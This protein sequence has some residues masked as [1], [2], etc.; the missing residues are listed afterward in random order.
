[1]IMKALVIRYGGYGDLIQCSSVFA[2]LHDQG[3]EVTLITDTKESQVVMHDPNLSSIITM[4]KSEEWIMENM[5]KYDKVICLDG[6]VEGHLLARPHSNPCFWPPDSREKVF[7]ENYL[8]RMH[9]I[10]GVPHVPQVRFYPTKEE[11]Q[12][13][14]DMK[15]H[16][17]LGGISFGEK[18]CIVAFVLKG[19]GVNKVWWG[20][21]KL[22]GMLNEAYPEIGIVLVGGK[23]SESLAATIKH[24]PNVWNM[25]GIWPIRTNMVFAAQCDIVIGPETGIMN[26]VCQHNNV[27]I[28]LLSHSTNEN[29]T[30][31]WINTYLVYSKDTN[32]FGRGQNQAKACHMIHTD[33]GLC[34]RDQKTG[35]AQCMAN[36]DPNDILSLINAILEMKR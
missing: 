12:W 5:S 2:G 20:F 36:T 21:E 6:V 27:K 4:P 25:T 26:S 34:T 32:C 18:K 16:F 30:R 24:H 11:L 7:N 1:M 19:T 14:D 29:L 28:V 8:E 10:A 9:L 35:N 33:F 22:A 13:A 23:D 3:Y 15:K 17:I 31:D